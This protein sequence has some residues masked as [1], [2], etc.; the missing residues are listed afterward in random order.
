ML[1]R[2]TLYALTFSPLAVVMIVAAPQ[3]IAQ[4]Q[5][6]RAG[7]FITSAGT[8]RGGDLGGL[9]GADQHCTALAKQAGL[10]TRQWRAYLST[11][12][13]NGMNARDRI[14]N[15]P[16]HNVKGQLIAQSVSDLHS[17]KAAINNDTALDERG[18]T[19]NGEGRPNRHDIL[20]GSTVEGRA[21]EMTCANW[22]SSGAGSATVG[23]HDR[24]AFG[25]PGSPWNSAHASR[26]CSQSDLVGSGGA[27]LIYCFAAD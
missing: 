2:I 10:P 3:P 24:L 20:T 15:G 25:T 19:I 8:G 4:A 13:A 9:S 27:G 1:R 18:Q 11:T 7:F 16:W 6:P 14:G 17:E 12:G 5:Q 26:G 21:T 22:T 23:H